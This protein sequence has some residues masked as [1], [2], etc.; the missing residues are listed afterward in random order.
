[1]VRT[2]YW[3]P[4]STS[5][6]SSPGSSFISAA[7][8]KE[9]YGGYGQS[10]NNVIMPLRD[11]MLTFLLGSKATAGFRIFARSGI[12][13]VVGRAANLLQYDCRSIV[14]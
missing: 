6:G 8:A 5:L 14:A 10:V 12:L 4:K 7:V 11:R 13:S 3:E 9:Y 1:M 2:P